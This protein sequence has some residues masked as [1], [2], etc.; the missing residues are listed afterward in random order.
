MKKVLILASAILLFISC[1]KHAECYFK[2]RNN[3]TDKAIKINTWS[4]NNFTNYDLPINTEIEIH[5]GLGGL[6]KGAEECFMI[7]YSTFDS[8][9]IFKIEDTSLIKSNK[10]F[11]NDTEWNFS[12][13]GDWVGTYTLSIDTTDF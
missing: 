10:Y 4:N 13:D 12:K 9:T 7:L 8:I 1:D 11:I 5:K 6:N 2:V 3:L